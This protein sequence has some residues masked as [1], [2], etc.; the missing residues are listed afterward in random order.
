M[1]RLSTGQYLG[2]TIG[3]TEFAGAVL[4][5]VRHATRRPLP[6]HSHESSYFSLLLDGHYMEQIGRA[7]L[8]YRRFSIGFHPAG[9]FHHDEVG[10]D[11]A[12]FFLVAVSAAWASRWNGSFDDS[13]NAAPRVLSHD[14][15]VVAARLWGRQRR[16]LLDG[17]AIDEAVCELLGEA[18]ATEKIREKTEPRWLSQC[19]DVLHASVDRPVPIVELAETLDLHPVYMARE[20]RRRFRRTVGDYARRLRIQRAC[21]LLGQR[22]RQLADIAAETGFADQSHFTRVFQATI[23]CSP[24]AYRSLL[25]RS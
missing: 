19:L 9:L 2:A 12:R 24:A 3:R 21:G 4:S 17:D 8:D 7:R 15:A 1:S 25:T 11:G 23:G 6:A 20:F 5:D 16:N 13:L 18:A 22:E 14:A 10:V